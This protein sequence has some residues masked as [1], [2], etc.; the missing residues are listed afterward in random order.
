MMFRCVIG[1]GIVCL[2][3]AGDRLTSLDLMA[4]TCCLISFVLIVDIFGAHIRKGESFWLGGC[5]D[6]QRHRRR[7]ESQGDKGEESALEELGTSG[8]VRI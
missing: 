7:Y 5:Q 6:A 4:T 1:V 3:L 8:N 2:P